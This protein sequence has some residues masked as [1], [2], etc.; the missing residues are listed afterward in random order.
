MNVPLDPSLVKFGIGQSVSRKEDPVLLR[1]EGRYTDD[2]SLP[3]QAYGVMV[4]SQYG[5]GILNGV[6]T[7]EAATLPGVLAI[8]TGH[9]LEAAG[10][11]PMPVSVGQ[12]NRD[13]SPARLPKQPVMRPTRCASLATQWPSSWQR[14]RSRHETPLRL[15][16]WTS[17]R[18]LP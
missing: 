17:S 9:D 6:D 12:K 7:T 3:G 14:Q 16:C 2:L 4:R 13:G 18:C 15:W 11:G 10:L 5:H 8:Y 1:G